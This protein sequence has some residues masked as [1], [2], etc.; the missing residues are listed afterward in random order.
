M[1]DITICIGSSCHLRGSRGVVTI[2]EKLVAASGLEEEINLRGSF[3]MGECEHGVCVEFE[4]KRYA[5]GPGNTEAFFRETVL[6]AV[7]GKA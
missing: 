1:K 5:L 7:G 6:P 2:L 4:G 3:C